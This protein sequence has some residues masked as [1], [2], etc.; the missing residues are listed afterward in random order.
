MSTPCA[1]APA[2]A[3]LPVRIGL[4]AGAGATEVFLDELSVGPTTPTVVAAFR[5]NLEG[6][7]IRGE[8]AG[9]I[10]QK[11]DNFARVIVALEGR[12]VAVIRRENQHVIARKFRQKASEPFVRLLQTFRIAARIAAMAV[13][14]VEINE[15]GE[16]ERIAIAHEKIFNLLL[17]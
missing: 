15:V 7:Q 16:D 12:I 3:A 17:R 4:V 11:W 1:G 14:H 13:E 8:M 2:A 10:N 9:A 5:A 6:R